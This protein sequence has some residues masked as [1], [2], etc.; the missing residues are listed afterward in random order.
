[1]LCTETSKKE[2][3]KLDPSI[4]KWE[5]HCGKES[6]AVS[7]KKTIQMERGKRGGGRNCTLAK[8]ERAEGLFDLELSREER[9]RSPGQVT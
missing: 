3:T 9:R 7:R 5:K 4:A 1:M 8:R 2:T 6:I